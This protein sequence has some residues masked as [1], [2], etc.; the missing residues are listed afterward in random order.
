M[1]RN[2]LES[3]IGHCNDDEKNKMLQIVTAGKKNIELFLN[4]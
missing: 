4:D 1:N 3:K 2:A